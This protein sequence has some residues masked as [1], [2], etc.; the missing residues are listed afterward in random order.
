MKKRILSI[1]LTLVMVLSLFVGAIPSMASSDG[2]TIRIHYHR[3]DGDYEDWDLW[4][5]NQDGPYDVSG[6][7]S[8]DG[9][10][11]D[12]PP[13]MFE[14]NGDE[15]VATI[16]VP[17]GTMRVGYIV[18]QVDWAGKDVPYDQFINITGILAGTIDFYIESGVPSQE[19]GMDKIPTMQ[20]LCSKVITYNGRSQN[21]MVLGDDVV[22][23]VVVMS[24]DYA[25]NSDQ[26]TPWVKVQLSASPG[27]TVTTDT[28]CVVGKTGTTGIT[29]IIKSGTY[30]YLYLENEL[31]WDQEYK[32]LFEGSYYNITLPDYYST[33]AFERKYTY[34]GNDLGVTYTKKKTTLRVWAPLAVEVQVWLYSNGDP[35]VQSDP[36]KTVSM[37]PD[38]NGTWVTTLSGDYNGTYYT[39]WVDNFTE[40]KEC[41]DPYA[42]TTG[43]NGRRGMIIDLDATDPA[44]WESDRDPHYDDA[45]TDAIIWEIH[46]RDFSIAPSSGVKES[47]RG[48]YLAFTQTGTTNSYGQ[49]TGVDYLKSL[50][51]THVH[52]MPVYDF[53]SVDEKDSSDSNWGYD[54]M[55]YNVPEGSYS[56]DPYKGEVRVKEFKQMVKG[57][58]DN[59]ISVIMD[60]V[61]NHV[62]DANQFC[63]NKIVPDYFSRPNSNGSGCGN[64]TAS[65][66]SMVRKYIVDSVLYWA[67]E[68]HIDGFRF[69]LVGLLDT[70]TINEIVETVHETHPNVI[71]Y[72]EGWSLTSKTT[73]NNVTLANMANSTKTPGLAFFSS[74]IRDTIKGSTFVSVSAG[75]ISGGYGSTGDMLKLFK[76]MPSWCKTPTQSINYLSCHDSY[77][78]YDHI[79]LVNAYESP[80]VKVARN[81]LGAAFYLTAQGVPFMQGGEEFLRSKPDA[82]TYNGYN[83]NSYNAPDSVNSLKWDS[84]NDRASSTTMAYYQGLIAFRK[85]HPALRM[86][87]AAMVNSNVFSLL[88]LDYNV[89]GYRINGGAN[90]DTAEG[91]VAIF[92]PNKDA[93]TVTLPEGQWHICVNKEQ[94]GTTSLGVVSGSVNV[95]GISAMI[96]VK[97]SVEGCA[98]P[99]HTTDGLCTACGTEV[100]HAY[101]KYG[102]CSCGKKLESYRT[103]Y[104]TGDW[105][106]VLYR[107]DDDTSYKPM[108]AVKDGL[109]ACQILSDAGTITFYD[110]DG[111]TRTVAVPADK[112]LFDLSQLNWGIYSDTEDDPN[113]DG[114]PEE[115][116]DPATPDDPNE[117]DDPYEPSD[118][119][120][121]APDEDTPTEETTGKKPS[122]N[123]DEEDEDNNSSVSI[124]LELDEMD[125][126]IIGLVGVLIIAGFTILIFLLIKRKK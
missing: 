52:L 28:F 76:G 54:P 51:I 86:T 90:A 125:L 22:K 21:M 114:T 6:K 49:S 119:E 115:P 101:D 75:Y 33:E 41:V 118:P 60:V 109:F 27:Y 124:T 53:G 37:T 98:H 88:D 20:Q 4:A 67:D 106:Q 39:Y 83:K 110:G 87:D 111:K 93:T 73:K 36:I 100:A 71:F 112:D 117:P 84:L 47:W 19:D 16:T 105:D 123:D 80:R 45:I 18:R 59:G 11:T 94:A 95:E 79:S 5:W 24:A 3:P 81:N 66:R 8:P 55:N 108:T 2:I 103:I 89:V 77:T 62:Y 12:T 46:V 64:D 92:N 43:V 14:P 74:D 10:P 1:L 34:P 44:G 48:K 96:L 65:E 68:Y 7:Q 38:V 120:G 116:D 17:T 15:V 50:G 82:S 42:R 58:H 32:L 97:G 113:V 104:F 107:C 9:T 26:G 63:M 121:E 40:Q 23:G 70:V 85:A 102:L 122:K 13:F 99:N 25:P 31:A 30:Y 78:L 126:I 69:D 61:Y 29:K 56:T 72:G 91:I 35:A 57:L